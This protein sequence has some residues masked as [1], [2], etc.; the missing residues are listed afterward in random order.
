VGLLVTY[1]VRA[2]VTI[3]LVV[4]AP[5]CIACHALPQTDGVARWW[6][7]SFAAVLAI[8]IAQALTLVVAIR[9]FLAPV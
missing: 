1:V 6:W 4:A 5:L 9:V 3:M 8:Q 7:R 2:V